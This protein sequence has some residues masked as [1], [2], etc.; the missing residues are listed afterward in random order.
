MDTTV[1]HDVLGR[2]VGQTEL[3]RMSFDPAQCNLNAFLEHISK[4]PGELHAAATRHICNFD[5]KYASVATGAVGHETSDDTWTTGHAV[6]KYVVPS[7]ISEVL[8]L[9]SRISCTR[10]R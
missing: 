1:L 10:P 9:L 4:L 5:E 7:V 2:I 8:Y 6:S 3:V